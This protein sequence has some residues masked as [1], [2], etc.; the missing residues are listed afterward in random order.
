MTA[1]VVLVCGPAGAGKSTHA[2]ALER[3]GYV[4]LSFDEAA[5]EQGLRE[6]PLPADA[7]GQVHAGLHVRL[8][9]LVAAGR[10][11]VVDTSFWSRASRDAY[12]AVLAP[13]GVVPV[14]HLLATPP[15]VVLRRL[16]GRTGSGPHDVVVPPALARAYLDG[17]EVP[18]ED[19]G[20][21]V[22]VAGGA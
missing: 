16:A 10:D 20:P 14:T 3:A 4:R 17:F 11:V 7:A 9:T 13:L 21:L 5:W 12:R 15:D 18:T 1:R 8:R 6:H 2:R 19:E 22:V